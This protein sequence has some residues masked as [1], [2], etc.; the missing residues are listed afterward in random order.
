MGFL[1]KLKAL[2]ASG[3]GR[4][5]DAYSLYYF[6]RCRRCRE[7]IKARADLR[8][9]LSAEYEGEN[10]SGYIYRKVIMGR[11][12]CFQQIEVKMAFDGQRRLTSREVTGGEFVTEEEYLKEAG[13]AG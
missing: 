4:S 2:F 1:D 7:V 10:T 9:E 11:G 5:A 6:V 12:R 13:K 8:N 3:P